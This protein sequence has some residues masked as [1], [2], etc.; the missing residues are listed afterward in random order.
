MKTQAKR[1]RRVAVIDDL[2]LLG[3]VSAIGG[4]VGSKFGGKQLDQKRFHE[5]LS[6]LQSEVHSEGIILNDF[7]KE[8]K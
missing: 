8:L 4:F 6:Q 5:D 2:L 7:Q 1:Q 3:A